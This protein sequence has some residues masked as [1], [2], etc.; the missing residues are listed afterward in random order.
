[1]NLLKS[2]GI[3]PSEKLK[4]TIDF[5]INLLNRYRN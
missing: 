4:K 2:K 5:Q 3:Y 1:M